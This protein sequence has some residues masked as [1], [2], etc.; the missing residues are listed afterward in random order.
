MEGKE[1]LKA[2]FTVTL[3]L[4]FVWL[5]A[6]DYYLSRETSVCWKYDVKLP[7]MSFCPLTNL[8][9]SQRPELKASLGR[10]FKWNCVCLRMHL[11]VCVRV[12]GNEKQI[13]L[14]IWL[15]GWHWMEQN[16]LC[17]DKHK[18]VQLHYTSSCYCFICSVIAK[19][20]CKLSIASLAIKW[21][22]PTFFTE[23]VSFHHGLWQ[24]CGITLAFVS[25]LM[26]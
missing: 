18:R 15:E 7:T 1:Y 13:A 4:F 20:D 23:C 16:F 22:S 8:A 5:G 14:P 3:P 25:G 9:V 26:W 24:A 2:W 12:C 10:H 19:C 11:H 21:T 6:V 17:E